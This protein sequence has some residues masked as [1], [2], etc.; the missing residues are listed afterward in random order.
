MAKLSFLMVI[1]H[2]IISIVYSQTPNPVKFYAT[3]GDAELQNG[4]STPNP[5]G[6]TSGVKALSPVSSNTFRYI[7]GFDLSSIPSDAV[8]TSANL[9]LT[10]S[11]SSAEAGLVNTSFIA[12][13]VLGA[14]SP[15]TT[16]YSTQ[17]AIQTTNH[18]ITSAYNSSTFKRSFNILN[19]V[20]AHVNRSIPMTGILIRRDNETAPTSNTIYHTNEATAM[21]NRPVLEITYI[22]VSGAS[23]TKAT[24]LSST[25]GSI[26]PTI[27]GGAGSL[28]YQWYQ[29]N[30][31][32]TSPNYNAIE[33]SGATA[34]SLNSRAYG[35]YGLRITSG[36]YNY[37]T[38]FL[39]GVQNQSVSIRFPQDPL[40]IDDANLAS[41]ASPATANFGND[42]NLRFGFNSPNTRTSLLKYRMWMDQQ[43]DITSAN[44]YLF[45]KAHTITANA[46]TISRISSHWSELSVNNNCIPSF[47]TDMNIAI[48]STTSTTQN[49]VINVTDYFKYWTNNPNSNFGFRFS[50]ATT[51]FQDYHSSD[52]SIT[53]VAKRPYVLF[54][55]FDRNSSNLVSSSKLKRELDGTY[56]TTTSDGKLKIYFEEEYRIESG[57][58]FELAIYDQNRVLKSKVD[59]NGNL[60]GTLPNAALKIA[61]SFD[62]NEK[63]LDLNCS[64]LTNNAYYVLEVL[65]STGEKRFLRFLFTSTQSC[66]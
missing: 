55:V 39:L 11:N 42:V 17:P 9:I 25:N 10:S 5:S 15:S 26:T 4:S 13:P 51:G 38:S 6:L 41:N 57:K 47:S 19:M 29:L 1:F 28:T 53:D 40:F 36:S 59:L 20:Q 54:T 33:I 21:S 27:E 30:T 58:F 45:G 31:A 24:T 37:Y 62:D 61:Y 2:T 32:P 18:V 48:A 34:S 65:T 3:L 14:W 52:A 16:I 64:G 35:W 7:L 23:I 56:V 22:L 46:S 12:S 44:L 60:S 8:I 50:G 66:F 63:V 49:Q 43:N